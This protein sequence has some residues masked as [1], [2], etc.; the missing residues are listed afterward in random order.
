[1]RIENLQ[2]CVGIAYL[3]PDSVDNPIIIE[4]H[5]DSILSISNFLTPQSV[6]MLF[7]DYNQ[8]GLIWESTPF[9]HA[10]H[11][12]AECTYTRSSIAIL[13]GMSLANM[14]QLKSITNRLNRTL[15]FLFINEKA[16]S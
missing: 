9:G 6:H 14:V 4:N 7:G 10:L 2:V 5:I 15:E 8:P 11:S 16:S 3:T 1:M 12:V 13:D